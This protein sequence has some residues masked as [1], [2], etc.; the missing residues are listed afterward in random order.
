MR[1]RAACAAMLVL[2]SCGDFADADEGTPPRS[3]ADAAT[4]GVWNPLALPGVPFAAVV[5]SLRDRVL[6]LESSRADGSVFV[7]QVSLASPHWYLQSVAGAPPVDRGGSSV[8]YDRL[9]DRLLL[10]GGT[11]LGD[12]QLW[13]LDLGGVPT[14]HRILAGGP[15]PGGRRGQGAIYDP[16]RDRM[17]IFGGQS[18]GPTTPFLDDVWTLS[19][20]DSTWSRMFPSG[21]SPPGRLDFVCDYDPNHE[22]MVVYGG[23]I[24][25]CLRD[26]WVLSLADDA[27]SPL[28]PSGPLP[29]GC[30]RAGVYDVARDRLIVASGT[31]DFHVLDLAGTPLWIDRS[32]LGGNDGRLVLDRARDRLVAIGGSTGGVRAMP[33]ATLSGWTSLLPPTPLTENEQGGAAGSSAASLYLMGSDAGFGVLG[34]AGCWSLP[35][36]GAAIWTEVPASG[37]PPPLGQPFAAAWDPIRERFVVLTADPASPFS[38]YQ[39]TPGADPAWSILPTSGTAPRSRQ[40]ATFVYD[41]L[42]DRFLLFGGANN[43]LAGRFQNDLWEL[44]LSPTPTWSPLTPAGMLPPARSAAAAVVDTAAQRLVVVGGLTAG[45]ALNDVWALDLAGPLAWTS[46]AVS[47]DAPAPRQLACSA[48]DGARSRMLVLWGRDAAGLDVHD[49]WSLRLV[50]PPTWTPLTWESPQPP[51]H[52]TSPLVVD[53]AHDRIVLAARDTWSLVF[54]SATGAAARCPDLSAVSRGETRDLDFEVAN[55]LASGQVVTW[56]VTSAR[57]WAGLPLRGVAIAGPADVAPVAV[58]VPVPDS[59]A[60]GDNTLS[61]TGRIAGTTQEVTCSS[62]VTIAP[63]SRLPEGLA[64]AGF[65]RNPDDRVELLFSLRDASP[66]RLDVFDIAGRRVESLDVGTM[67]AGVHRVR[68]PHEAS[69]R[70]GVYLVLLEQGGRRVV[71]RGVLVR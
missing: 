1:Y 11:V 68:A 56:D 40:D 48:Y 66:A 65:S 30:E 37:T 4:D 18:G 32:D 57:D 12:D 71:R 45:A 14:W 10:F 13:A 67:G 38:A 16:V 3:V 5:D 60:A 61:F 64:L 24:L 59:A 7:W 44:S 19:L 23:G 52:T 27:W 29:G 50:D 35:R 31:D 26:A 47:G 42:H 22:R 15:S 33:L 21:A 49:S 43:E 46:L 53:P 58:T 51:P 63:S 6:V 28:L 25:P 20:A 39:L 54:E 9:R 41:A 70:S 8:V 36:E 17:W 62:R 69:F 2:A 55:P 34:S